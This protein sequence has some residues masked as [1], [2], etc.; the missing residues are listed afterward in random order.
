MANIL[1]VDDD[2]DTVELCRD[3]LESAGHQVR[4]GYTGEDG[5]KSLEAGPLPDCVLLDVDMPVLN[6]PGMAHKMLLDRAHG[7]AV[8][9]GEGDARL[10]QGSPRNPRARV[11]R[12]TAARVRLI[13]TQVAHRMHLVPSEVIPMTTKTVKPPIA[14]RDGT[15]HLNPQYE[16]DLR[17]ISAESATSKDAPAF[18]EKDKVE[19]LSEQLA[20]SFVQRVTSGEDDVLDPIVVEE[21]GGPFIE[22]TGH[23][24]LAGGT[25]PSNP[26]GAKRE[27]FPTT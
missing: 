4:A 2:L 7:D 20:E 6:G 21:S 1:I 13:G 12:A 5:L 26:K 19:P 18:L 25:D 14:R 8:L 11:P 9:P 23:T 15:G 3:L 10:W 27:P 22:T 17:A 16:A 24:E